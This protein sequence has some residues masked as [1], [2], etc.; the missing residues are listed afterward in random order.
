MKSTRTALS[1]LIIALVCLAVILV[2]SNTDIISKPA[3]NNTES[4]TVAAS[5]PSAPK[6][7]VGEY[8]GKLAVFF[9]E[10][11]TPTLIYEVRVDSLPEADAALLKNGIT[12]E[13]D[14]ELR[15]I[16]EDYTS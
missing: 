1:V 8:D 13:T 15:S 3:A 16:V 2:L 4:E 6:Y 11:D 14:A 10:S 9:G 12:A 7:T 5:S